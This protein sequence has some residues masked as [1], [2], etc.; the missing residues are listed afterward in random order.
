MD[1]GRVDALDD[2]GDREAAD[3]ADL[4]GLGHA[5]GD[6]ADDGA[7]FVKAGVIGRKVLGSLVAGGV[8]EFHIGEFLGDVDGRVHE[9]K[10]GGEDQLVAGQR[11][12]GQRAFGIGALRHAFDEGGFDPV[13]I[14][15][16][17]GLTAKV[18]LIGPAAIAHGADIDKADLQLFVLRE[19]RHRRGG[20]QRGGTAKKGS[21]FHV[22]LLLV[23]AALAQRVEG[24]AQRSGGSPP[25]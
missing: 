14:F 8:L 22:G 18:V 25:A 13:A 21:A 24:P 23:C 17:D 9:A 10:A 19:C 15:L 16:F 3:I 6:G 1:I 7:A 11:Q 20:D 5:S 12:L 4:V 2:L